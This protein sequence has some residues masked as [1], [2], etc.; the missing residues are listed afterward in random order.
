MKNLWKKFF[1]KPGNPD[2]IKSFI[3]LVVN[4]DDTPELIRHIAENKPFLSCCLAAVKADQNSNP[5]LLR[6]Y[7]DL[8]EETRRQ[9]FSFNYIM[10][11]LAPVASALGLFPETPDSIH[12]NYYDIL[13][14][15]PSADAGTIK[16]AF[17]KKAME[18]HPDALTGEKDRFI[19]IHEAYKVLSEKSSRRFYDLRRKNSN[20]KKWSEDSKIQ[21]S[22]P[23]NGLSETIYRKLGLPVIFITLLIVGTIV[24]ADFF[25]QEHSLQDVRLDSQKNASSLIAKQKHAI[26]HETPAIQKKDSLMKNNVIEDNLVNDV[27]DT[28]SLTIIQKQHK[29]IINYEKAIEA[30][31]SEWTPK[32]EKRKV[33][34]KQSPDSLSLS[35]EKSE[36]KNIPLKTLS[37]DN[38]ITVKT[39]PIKIAEDTITD[40]DTVTDKVEKKSSGLESD[41]D[42]V[43]IKAKLKEFLSLYCEAYENLD[44]NGFLSFFA[45]N[46]TENGKPFYQLLPQYKKNFNSLASIHYTINL[47]NYRTGANNAHIELDGQFALRWRKKQEKQWHS[48]RGTIH[49]GLVPKNESFA[50]EKLNYQFTN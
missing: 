18:S 16:K 6:I 20:R 11:K 27:I 29:Q 19:A 12:D 25:I 33:V 41:N 3:K 8:K 40:E 2:L 1:N 22:K 24:I 36:E 21:S 43:Q 47:L 7:H 32:R 15:Q 9:G 35:M 44:L 13:G 14:I 50:V 48:Y 42:A 49:M 26:D 28:K 38:V 17:R 37:L 34:D 5:E 4:I 45:D 39:Q 30:K 46:A 23:F 31:K 10:E